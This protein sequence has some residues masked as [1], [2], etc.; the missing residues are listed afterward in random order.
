SFCD[1][2]RDAETWTAETIAEYQIAHVRDVVSH[3]AVHSPFYRR[4][5]AEAGF[6]PTSLATLADLAQCPTLSKQDL[7]HHLDDMPAHNIAASRRLYITTGGSTGVPV[8]FYLQKGVSRPKEQAFLEA[9]W[10]RA[11]YSVGDRVAVIRGHV[12][13][14]LAHGEV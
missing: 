10:R 13:S 12:T 3:A 5:F 1:L 7:L 11:G 2:A 14:N 8:G 9:Q 4:R 6:D